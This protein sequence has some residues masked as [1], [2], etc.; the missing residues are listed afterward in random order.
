MKKYKLTNSLFRYI[1]KH[2]IKSGIV[3]FFLIFYYFCLP[4]SLFNDPT[5][6]VITSS[7]NQ[8]LGAQISKDGQWRFP[9]NDS[10]PDK[11]KICITT[12]EDEY[13][14]KHPG[15]NPISIFKALKSRFSNMF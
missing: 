14:Y 15:F 13:F 3:I 8:L 4:K 5:A 7:T 6:T 11:F 9:R 1:K 12:F 10:V 2:K